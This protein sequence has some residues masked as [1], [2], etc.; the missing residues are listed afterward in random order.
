MNRENEQMRIKGAMDCLAA[1]RKIE[2][3]AEN[4]PD[5]AHDIEGHMNIQS[6]DAKALM[7]LF[8]PMTSYQ[9]GAFLTLAEYIHFGITT[10]QP[11]LDRW[12]PVAAESAESL[13]AYIERWRIENADE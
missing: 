13:K 5:S 4:F 1:L 6:G 9:Q 3:S 8:G 2:A 12:M 11:D 10:G 7:E